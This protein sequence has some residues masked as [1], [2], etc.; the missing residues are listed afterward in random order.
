MNPK[1]SPSTKEAYSRIVN[2]IVTEF[3]RRRDEERNALIERVRAQFRVEDPNRTEEQIDQL[4]EPQMEEINE[5]I[6][7]AEEMINVDTSSLLVEPPTNAENENDEA[8]NA[9]KEETVEDANKNESEPVNIAELVEAVRPEMRTETVRARPF[10][11]YRRDWSY[12]I[13]RT[14]KMT[15]RQLAE[16]MGSPKQGLRSQ[17]KDDHPL[18]PKV[19]DPI[20]FRGYS[21]SSSESEAENEAPASASASAQ[22]ETST[23]KK[24]RNDNSSEDEGPA[25]PR[26][27]ARAVLADITDSIAEAEEEVALDSSTGDTVDCNITDCTFSSKSNPKS[28]NTSQTNTEE[29]ES[30]KED[31]EVTS[32]HDESEKEEGEITSS[33]EEEQRYGADDTRDGGPYETERIHMT[34]SAMEQARRDE[35]DERV[36]VHYPEIFWCSWCGRPNSIINDVPIGRRQRRTSID[37][38]LE[39][40]NAVTDDDRRIFPVGFSDHEVDFARTNSSGLPSYDQIFGARIPEGNFQRVG[41]PLIYSPVYQAVPEG[42]NL[43]REDVSDDDM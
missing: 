36:M 1:W 26:G 3:N 37:T 14:A 27:L 33:D 31:G 34:D 28:A 5:M 25:G 43:V 18:V 10:K 19:L 38:S 40:F 32:N 35:E 15:L 13:P 17:S 24:Q 39:E 7:M 16:L 9:D 4:I 30:E 42:P 29:S 12:R 21:S 2:R 8:D 20:Q 6:S 23:P 41:P 22:P 11:R